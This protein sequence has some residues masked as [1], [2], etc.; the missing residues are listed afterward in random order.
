MCDLDT[1]TYVQTY[2]CTHT[3]TYIHTHRCAR[4]TTKVTKRIRQFHEEVIREMKNS[5]T[6]IVKNAIF[7]AVVNRDV[8]ALFDEFSELI[9]FI[10]K[11]GVDV[12]VVSCVGVCTRFWFNHTSWRAKCG[13][14]FGHMYVYYVHTY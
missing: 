11:E 1:Y 8:D 5:S 12:A 2:T 3:H 7:K 10:R 9:S 4:L 14:R 13:A 6:T